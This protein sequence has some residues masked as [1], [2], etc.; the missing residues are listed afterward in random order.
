MEREIKIIY[1][2][3]GI[4]VLDKPAGWITTREGKRTG[5]RYVEDW[6]EV[7][8]PNDLPRN[9]IVHRLDKGTSGLL[10]TAKNKEA[11]LELKK[12]F[13][14]RKVVKTYLALVEGKVTSRGSV[15]AP[16][17]RIRVRGL[18][19]FGVRVGGRSAL[20]DFELLKEYFRE[21]NCLPPL[22]KAIQPDA[23]GHIR[24]LL[25]LVKVIIHSG[26]THQIRVHLS[27]LGWPLV[28]DRLYGGKDWGLGRPFLHAHKLELG[29]LSL[30]SPL[31][32]DLKEFLERNEN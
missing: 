32:K 3:G 14:E 2:D 25:R 20:T 30:T 4:L 28:G 18:G 7:N 13:K 6:L 23:P 15:K 12:Q 17:G 5:S 9:G 21:R 22:G 26:R 24:D 27:Y 19:R 8:H 11:W 1:E 29:N 31:A 16:V 10:V